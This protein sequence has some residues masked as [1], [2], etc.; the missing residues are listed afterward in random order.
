MRLAPSP[1][2][3]TMPPTQRFT[4]VKFRHSPQHLLLRLDS[5]H[6][7]REQQS[8]F[9]C[10]GSVS[11]FKPVNQTF[12]T[13]G[14]VHASIHSEVTRVSEACM[15]VNPQNTFMQFDSS[16]SFCREAPILDLFRLTVQGLARQSVYSP[17]NHQV[18]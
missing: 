7:H 11:V 15:H 9:T 16:S 14:H 4:W 12:R 8:T 13:A 1:W 18:N 5:H 17:C 3:R 10:N 2:S 6:A